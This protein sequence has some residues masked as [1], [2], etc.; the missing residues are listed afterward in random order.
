MKMAKINLVDEVLKH[1]DEEVIEYLYGLVAGIRRQYNN[2]EDPMWLLASC[3]E[4][5]QVYSVLKGLKERNDR[6]NNNNSL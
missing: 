5:E 1:T 2:V 6:L 4:V 3:G